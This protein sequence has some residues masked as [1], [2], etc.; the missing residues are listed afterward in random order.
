MMAIGSSI[1]A[2]SVKHPVSMGRKID[3]YLVEHLPD[4]MDEYKIADRNDI[5]DLDPEFEGYEKRMTDLEGWKKEFD[6]RLDEGSRRIERLRRKYGL[7][8]GGKR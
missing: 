1:Q 2:F 5:A 3:H 4:L 6:Q 7:I 8:G